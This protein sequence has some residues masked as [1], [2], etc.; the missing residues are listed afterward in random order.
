MSDTY[1]GFIDASFLR[2]E[3]AKAIGQS[4]KG[5]R[6]DAQ[7]VVSWCRFLSRQEAL[8]QTFLRT[9]WYD[10]RFES[11]HELAEGQRR[12]FSALGQ[13]PGIQ[14]RLGHIV[15]YRPW[16]EQG[17][18]DALT[19]TAV[20]LNL[21]PNRVMEEF[22]R[23]W[24]FRPERRQRGVDTMLC[25]DIVRLAGRRAF[26]TAVIFSGDRDLQEA[27]RS[28]QELGARVVIATPD[29]HSVS[30]EM[31]DLADEILELTEDDLSLMLPERLPSLA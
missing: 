21:D 26:D 27:V 13:T 14:L 9:Y 17:I 29:R 8:H 31:N 4:P 7:A 15:E 24:T 28:S 30:R 1:A 16:F 20:S 6:P 19:R 18:R 23:Q 22:D 11:G 5:V 10:A 3:G 25:S 2:S 12:F